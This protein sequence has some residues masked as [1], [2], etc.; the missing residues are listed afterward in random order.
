LI[1]LISNGILGGEVIPSPSITG[2]SRESPY[3]EFKEH[4]RN[5]DR[6]RS[7]RS[8]KIRTL[9]VFLLFFGVY[10]F[11]TQATG[12]GGWI[13]RQSRPAW[14]ALGVKRL[15]SGQWPG[16]DRDRPAFFRVTRLASFNR[17]SRLKAC[18]GPSPHRWPDQKVSHPPWIRESARQ[19]A[20][21]RRPAY[22]NSGATDGRQRLRL[23][24][25]R[26]H[27]GTVHLH[28]PAER[29][30]TGRTGHGQAL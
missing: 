11:R 27:F 1:A 20:M 30:I 3:S 19:L 21:T 15:Y 5:Y 14:S 29:R 22:P 28:V 25:W 4:I 23:R 13:N 24:T 2:R 26:T 6:D 10:H 12:N 9:Q 17:Q 8:T 18:L 16:S 7:A